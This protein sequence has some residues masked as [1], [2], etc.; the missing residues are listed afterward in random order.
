MKF[1]IHGFSLAFLRS[2]GTVKLYFFV[3][4]ELY[5]VLSDLKNLAKN[6]GQESGQ[7]SGQNLAKIWPKTRACRPCIK[8]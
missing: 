2:G 3:P 1:V 5:T 7:K 4:V 8:T 6:P